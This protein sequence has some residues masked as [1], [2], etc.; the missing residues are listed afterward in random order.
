M[1]GFSFW[2]DNNFTTSLTTAP[3]NSLNVNLGK[4]F[5]S[6]LSKWNIFHWNH[7]VEE[8][9]TCDLKGLWLKG[10]VLRNT[11]FHRRITDAIKIKSTLTKSLCTPVWLRFWNDIILSR[12]PTEYSARRST[13]LPSIPHHKASYNISYGWQIHF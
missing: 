3:R 7:I 6:F 8:G 13:E 1:T 10:P 9:T 12:E 11:Y 4:F 2:H 5:F